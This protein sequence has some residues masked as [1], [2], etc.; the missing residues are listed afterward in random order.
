MN[1]TGVTRKIIV[2]SSSDKLSEAEAEE[3][4]K[5]LE[6]LKQSPRDDEPN[7]L[8]LL[9]G[10]RVYEE[11]TG[12]EREAVNRAMMQFERVLAKQD[13]KEIERARK[14]LNK[15]LDSIETGG[16]E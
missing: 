8:A 4:L 5:R 6:Y 3:R 9:R 13:R 10:E 12:W 7:K 2:Q 15:L 11:S 14:E 16:L 1:S